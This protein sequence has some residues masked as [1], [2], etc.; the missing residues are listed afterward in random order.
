M[1][2][3][4]AKHAEA[5]GEAKQKHQAAEAQYRHQLLLKR[6]R[7]RNGTAAPADSDHAV[8]VALGKEAGTHQHLEQQ[9]HEAAAD[10]PPPKRAKAT[11]QDAPV[12]GRAVQQQQHQRAQMHL[13]QKSHA[14][15][16]R[17][18]QQQ[19][20]QQQEEQGQQQQGH[21]SFWAEEESKAQHP[22]KEVWSCWVL[23]ATTATGMTSIGKVLVQLESCL[24]HYDMPKMTVDCSHICS[25][26]MLDFG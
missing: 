3:D 13:S 9:Q 12:Q 18:Q 20:Q 1:Q 5:E 19:Q 16:E 24:N 2:R 23:I 25:S 15:L 6:A 14:Q 22:D 21:I 11:V 17:H 10:H 7:E 4:E 26:C 8:N